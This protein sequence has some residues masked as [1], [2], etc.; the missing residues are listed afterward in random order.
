LVTLIA[1][2]LARLSGVGAMKSFSAAVNESDDPNH[3]HLTIV[4]LLR[5]T[6]AEPSN[7]RERSIGCRVHRSADC[8]P[9]DWRIGL[10][11]MGDRGPCTDPLTLVRFS[12]FGC[13]VRVGAVGVAS[14]TTS[15]VGID[16]M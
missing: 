1:P 11:A 6:L 16:D 8:E 10:C 3:K 13:L 9:P 7:L 14:G 12:L 15:G 5:K 2:Q 4:D